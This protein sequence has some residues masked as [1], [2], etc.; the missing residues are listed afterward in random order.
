MPAAHAHFRWLVGLETAFSKSLATG[1]PETLR[2]IP[3]NAN[4]DW[5]APHLWPRCQALIAAFAG[6]TVTRDRLLAESR[7]H[8]E[9]S[10]D[11]ALVPSEVLMREAVLGV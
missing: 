8:A 3:L 10:I 7:R 9:D 5:F 6:D 4:A 1:A 11:R 2:R